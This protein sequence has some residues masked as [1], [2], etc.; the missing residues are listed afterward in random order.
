MN[1]IQNEMSLYPYNGIVSRTTAKELTD[2]YADM[3][4]NEKL[5]L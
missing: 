2:D 3:A 5:L 1:Y 4:T